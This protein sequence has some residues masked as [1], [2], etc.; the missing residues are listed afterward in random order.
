MNGIPDKL[1]L[2]NMIGSR[3]DAVSIQEFQIAFQFDGSSSIVVEGSM[4]VILNG[5]IVARWK[6]DERWSSIDFQKC[7]GTTVERFAI[8]SKQELDL[9]LSGGW[10]LRFYDDSSQYES[11]HIY[12]QDSHV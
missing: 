11:F 2:S 6:Q 12:P 1:D 9:Y 5:N 4:D 7:V 3:L 10:V 8:P